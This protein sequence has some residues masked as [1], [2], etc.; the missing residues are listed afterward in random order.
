MGRLLTWLMALLGAFWLVRK[1]LAPVP[2]PAGKR[3]PRSAGKMVRDAVCDTFLPEGSALRL[4]DASGT[5]FFCSTR[6]RDH[7]LGKGKEVETPV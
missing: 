7:F 4:D 6:C 1:I 3:A 2:R 5:H